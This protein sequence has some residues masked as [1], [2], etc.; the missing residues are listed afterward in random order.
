V[1]GVAACLY[2][3]IVEIYL[4]GGELGFP[5][6]DSWIHLQFA[7]NLFAG[8][9]LSFNPGVLVPG[10]TAPLWT[11][12]LSLLFYLPGNPLFWTKLLGIACY[13]A[14]G[15]LTY[16]LSRELGLDHGPANLAAA[17]TLATSWLVWSALSGL[18]I[19]LFVVLS[20]AGILFHIKERRDP[21]R[22]PVSLPILALSFLARP[23][24]ALLILAAVADR[25]LVFRRNTS[26]SAEWRAGE[27]YPVSGG[28]GGMQRCP[29][30]REFALPSLTRPRRRSR[31]I[32][33][34]P[35]SPGF[36]SA[37]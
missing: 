33:G 14:G 26:G 21:E 16:R 5:L 25:L 29:P 37:A 20:L 2:Y 8:E 1:L 36:T 3:L 4:L 22:I 19:S 6:D 11:A 12:L 32:S 18:E 23:E 31:S 17:V 13:L 15:V 30:R 28:S 35:P 9:G 24:A 27:V 34:A 7:R 10:S